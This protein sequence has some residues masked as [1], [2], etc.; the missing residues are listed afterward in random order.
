MIPRGQFKLS[1]VVDRYSTHVRSPRLKNYEWLYYEHDLTTR[2]I[3]SKSKWNASR[4]PEAMKV[5]QPYWITKCLGLGAGTACNSYRY[6]I[7]KLDDATFALITVANNPASSKSCEVA[8]EIKPS[9]TRKYLL[10]GYTSITLIRDM[11]DQFMIADVGDGYSTDSGIIN[12][13]TKPD[14]K[15]LIVEAHRYDY[16]ALSRR[17]DVVPS[18]MANAVVE[19]RPT[20]ITPPSI[21]GRGSSGTR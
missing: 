19:R 9:F 20:T 14:N 6:K 2:N 7:V 12:L 10:R 21:S 17:F 8:S 13:L 15:A 3:V 16:E 1:D 4:D 18:L 5:G 11:G